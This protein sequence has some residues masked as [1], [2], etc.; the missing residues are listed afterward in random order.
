M[1]NTAIEHGDQQI[2]R[3]EP[4]TREPKAFDLRDV[5]MSAIIIKEFATKRREHTRPARRVLDKAQRLS[6]TFNQANVTEE[7]FLLALV[8]DPEGRRQADKRGIDMAKPFRKLLLATPYATPNADLTPNLPLSEGVTR[9]MEYAKARATDR[10]EDLDLISVGDLLE[11]ALV[12][13]VA[14]RA[15]TPIELLQSQMKLAQ[16]A[17]ARGSSAASAAAVL[18]VTAFVAAAVGAAAFLAGKGGLGWNLLVG[19]LG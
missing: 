4:A 7:M 9:I 13:P 11:A 15:G 17:R 3:L 10:E 8:L 14:P 18:T 2:Q 6:A 12:L 1:T 5:R 19:W 16:A